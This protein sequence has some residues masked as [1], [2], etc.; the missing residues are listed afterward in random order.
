MHKII[1]IAIEEQERA[2]LRDEE[3]TKDESK[4][5]PPRSTFLSKL[6]RL[7]RSE[8]IPLERDRMAGNVLTL[9]LAGTDTTSKTLNHAL[10]I[11]AKD[12]SLQQALRKEAFDVGDSFLESATLNDL[13]TQ[14]P[15][16]K[17]FLHEMHRHYGN[18][19]FTMTT[20]VDVPFCGDTLPAG[21]HLICMAQ[22]IACNKICPSSSVPLGP[23]GEAPHVF[24]AERYLVQQ[25]NSKNGDTKLESI[26]PVARGGGFNGFGFGIRSCPGRSFSE[27]LSYIVLVSLLQTFDSFALAPNC[28]PDAGIVDDVIMVPDCQVELMLRL[29]ARK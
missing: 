6:L 2:V 28:D 24:C 19:V 18:P 7:M 11:L 22:Y 23:N 29:R 8:R 5:A 27:A 4:N 25:K 1:S 15:R 20:H 13:Y 10:Y 14:L 12:A 17:S 9:F 21:T 3:T 26:N 16:I